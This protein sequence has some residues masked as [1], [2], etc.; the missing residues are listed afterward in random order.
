MASPYDVYETILHLLEDQTNIHSTE[1]EYL[2]KK[3][4]RDNSKNGGYSLF[5]PVS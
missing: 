1:S 4:K 5:L 2:K 3:F